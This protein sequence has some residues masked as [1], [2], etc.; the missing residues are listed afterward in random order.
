[1]ENY[2]ITG[3]KSMMSDIFAFLKMALSTKKGLAILA[4]CTFVYFLSLF[5]SGGVKIWGLIVAILAILVF[6][7]LSWLIWFR[8]GSDSGEK[9]EYAKSY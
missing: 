5:V 9:D 4:V 2:P 1:M 7:V 3:F 8:A 6:F